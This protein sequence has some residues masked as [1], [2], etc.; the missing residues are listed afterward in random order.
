MEV[1]NQIYKNFGA[2]IDDTRQSRRF[3]PEYVSMEL[4]VENELIKF[5]L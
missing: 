4:I 5:V 1:M 2:L 3:G